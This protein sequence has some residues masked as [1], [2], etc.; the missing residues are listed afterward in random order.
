M[1]EA[2]D[3][4][5]SILDAKYEAANL[6]EICNKSIHLPVC[7]Q[8]M[9]FELLK[10]HKPL[11][12]GTLGTWNDEQCNIDL[13]PDA[14][15]YHGRA[16]PIPRVHLETIKLEV[17]HLCDL[18]VLKKVNR[19]EWA[20]PTFITKKKDGS[21]HFI[22]DFCELNKHGLSENLIQYL[23]SRIYYCS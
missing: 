21:V 4:L 10:K 18:G 2:A 3:R 7:E 8:E 13:R 19:S 15:P 6:R 11:F 17:Q 23:E 5:R 9:L 12:D 22:S 20:A 1:E 16:F 14:E